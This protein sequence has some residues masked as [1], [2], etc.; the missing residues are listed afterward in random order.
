MALQIVIAVFMTPYILKHITKEEY[1]TYSI[2]L[3]SI[4]FFSMFNFGFGGALGI[5]VSRNSKDLSLVSI[6]GSVVQAFQFFLGVSGLLIGVFFQD[7]LI[8]TMNIIPKERESFEIVIL[9]F[10]LGFFFTMI[11]Q[12]YS[13]ILVS[14]RQIHIDNKI[15]I[16]TNIFSIILIVFFLESDWGIIGLSM[17]LLLTQVATFTISLLRVRTSFSEIRINPFNLDWSCFRKLYE[18]GLWIFLGSF[19]IFIIEKFDQFVVAKLLTFEMVTIFVIS[20]KIFEI[21][22]KFISMLSN[23][24]RPYYGKFIEEGHHELAKESF[25]AVRR[26][27]IILSIVVACIITLCNS[28]FIDIW[29]GSDYYAGDGANLFLGLNLIYNSWKLP[30]R[31][32]LTANLIVKE[33]SIFGIAEGG[34]N[35][36]VSLLLGFEYGL[37]GIL[38]GTFLSGFV[39]QLFFYGY[40][41]N[42]H[43]L[44]FYSD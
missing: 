31:A 25:H 2:A 37:I 40:L 3:G 19:S 9:L 12:V 17:S 41:L 44:E 1:G 8:E 14:Y 32:Y 13:T 4:E 24:F 22:K 26:V 42:K 28:Y 20:S 11:N 10:S 6:Q 36:F 34:L 29:V 30:N 15:G 38:A 23:N 7:W 39:I 16:F 43:R 35:V 5:L 21:S 18:I 33:Q 27:S